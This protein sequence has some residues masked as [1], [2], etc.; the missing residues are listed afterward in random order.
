MTEIIFIQNPLKLFWNVISTI[1]PKKQIV[2]DGE[3]LKSSTPVNK[4][5]QR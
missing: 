5:N 4:K 1:F 3:I 2:Q